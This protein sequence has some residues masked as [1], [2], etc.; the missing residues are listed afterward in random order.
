MRCRKLGNPPPNPRR[1]TNEILV[2]SPKS[3]QRNHDSSLEF[4][5]DSDSD[6]VGVD[7]EMV[8]NKDASIMKYDSSSVIKPVT[9][10]ISVY[11]TLN[12]VDASAPFHRQDRKELK[13]GPR[14]E[15][16]NNK[17]AS[18]S[19]L[20]SIVKSGNYAGKPFT[21]FVIAKYLLPLWGTI[22]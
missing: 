21:S 17:S 6:D 3:R 7:V 15:L 12:D 9:L 11:G 16:L 4:K 2:S 20:L 10:I 5:H 13:Y 22:S 18:F 8:E 1:K 14:V 19:D